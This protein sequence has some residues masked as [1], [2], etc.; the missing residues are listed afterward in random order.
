[1]QSASFRFLRVFLAAGLALSGCASDP[2]SASAGDAAPDGA[3]GAGGVGG[4]GG[5][6]GA[7]GQGGAGGRDATGG[8][9][10]AGP[11]ADAGPDPDA[12]APVACDVIPAPAVA[13]LLTRL[14]YDHILRDVLGDDTGPAGQLPPENEVL[15]FD[16]NAEFHRATPA[17]VEGLL[18]VAEDVAARAA[19][20]LEAALVC[21]GE[22]AACAEAFLAHT[23]RRL[24]RR[25][26]TADE[27]TAFG[28]LFART[29][30]SADRPTALRLTLTALLQSPQFLYRLEEVGPDEIAGAPTPLSPV[31][32]AGRLAAFLW[33]SGPDDALLDAA[34]QGNLS[35][36]A[37]VRA[38]V[39]RMLDDPRARD[40]VRHFHRQWLGLK[41]MDSMVK[42]RAADFPGGVDALRAAYA[43]SIYSFIEEAFWTDG[44]GMAALLTS[45]TL[46]LTPDLA[47]LF[48][49]EVPPGE[50]VAV[51][52]PEERAGLITQPALMADLAHADQTS[53]IH[54]G[55]FVRERL[56]CQT[57]P[58]PPNNV[59][60]EPPRVDPNTTTRERFAQHT[61]DDLCQGCHTLIDPVGFGFE[62]YDELGRV[63]TTDNG[64]PVDV[65][66]NLFDP[67]HP[68]LDG[69]FNGA[70]ELANRLAPS[71]EVRKCVATHWFRYAQARGEQ[72][73]DACALEKVQNAFISSG[74]FT[75]LL[76]EL[77]TGDAFRLRP[78][79]ELGAI[80]PL[81]DLEP[82]PVDPPPVVDEGRA[83]L[84]VLDAVTPEGQ[85]RG[86][87]FDPDTP[88]QAA[89]VELYLDGAPGVGLF[90]G[91]YRT[92]Q[93][94]PDVVAAY[95]DAPG[96]HG[97]LVTL[98]DVARDGRPHQLYALARNSG[99]GDDTALGGTP[100]AFR[101]GLNAN[102]PPE[103]NPP[104]DA[105]LPEGYLDVVTREGVASGWAL[106]RDAT[107]R[108]LEIH[109]FL[110]GPAFA[111]GTDLGSTR[112]GVP[113]PDVNGA[114][115]LPGDH[116]W[117]FPLPPEVFDG[118]QHRLWAYAFNAGQPGSFLLINSPV[119]FLL[120]VR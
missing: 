43:E 59:V 16:N 9:A 94:R 76:V 97:F 108:T 105:F 109:F 56:L 42:D 27:R 17:L 5:A 48:G 87:A 11:P 74:S 83:P 75:D 66:G 88:G 36:R 118:Q 69:P 120:E 73:T 1:M 21:N 47:H 49:V 104:P 45:P 93:P 98:P 67:R 72:P 55:I 46:H 25:T 7:G 113:R 54:R 101:A 31:G 15:G 22:P 2:T 107:D 44:D 10:D 32:L 115:G 4:V 89:L 119:P 96:V 114:F 12:G 52:F 51:S 100:V 14:E 62:G 81:P 80:P 6:G 61:A 110:D 117:R 19:D 102:P 23:G 53:P 85:A 95:P 90:L 35:T 3:A 37:A 26:L 38:Q 116:G 33:A 63:R 91:G 99:R 106:D 78:G 112:T 82:E 41:S 79:V 71:P 86:W 57:L 77:A 40:A 58:P 111:G 84:G 60:I 13:R 65:S 39:E 50:S 30:E 64:R 20:R 34:E 70:L 18:S 29:M 24:F 92:D 68:N 28:E 103:A 8:T